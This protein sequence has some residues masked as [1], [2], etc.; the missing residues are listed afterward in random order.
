MGYFLHS[1]SEVFDVF[2]KFMAHV[3]NQFSTR[4]KVLR[5]DSGEEYTLHQFQQFLQKYGILS[6]WSY[7]YTLQH[8]GVAERKNRHLLD[9]VR[10]LLLASSVPARF[11]PEALGTAVHL[12]NRI[13]STRLSNQS[14][15]YRLF[16]TQPT[17]THVLLDACVLS[18][19]LHLSVEN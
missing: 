5:S 15:Y 2:Q 16:H 10:S 3:E 6:Q 14:P 13:P 19:S 8:N 4:M 11:W 7:P 17:Y 18:I 9:I 1:K 12:I